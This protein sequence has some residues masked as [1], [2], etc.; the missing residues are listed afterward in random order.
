MGI[1][2]AFKLQRRKLC[3]ASP[4]GMEILGLCFKLFLD[5]FDYI[6]LVA[7]VVGS[8]YRVKWL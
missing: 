7:F 5:A 8:Q 3:E 1:G 2:F 6:A 4:W